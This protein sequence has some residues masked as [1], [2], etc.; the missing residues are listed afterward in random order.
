MNILHNNLIIKQHDPLMQSKHGIYIPDQLLEKRNRGVVT[1]IGTDIDPELLGK[2]VL[3]VL[4]SAR[5]F[6]HENITG[7]IIFD[8]DI[9]AT[10]N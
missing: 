10:L 3:F 9:I 1:H 7:K 4:A 8:T 5:D 6:N 2:E